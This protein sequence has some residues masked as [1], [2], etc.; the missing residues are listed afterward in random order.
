MTPAEFQ[1]A[2]IAIL[3]TSVGWQSKIADRLG[4]N[5]RAVRRWLV[6]GEIPDTIAAEMAA[7]MGMADATTFPRGE[8]LVGQDDAGRD[9]IYHMQAPR[10]IAR[11]IETDA[12][13]LPL[14]EDQP[15]DVISGGPY[16]IDGADDGDLVLCEIDW[17][18][19]PH[20]GEITQ[21]MEAAADMIEKIMDEDE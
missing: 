2:A 11:I 7:L 14:P 6:D 15:A 20:T 21:L 18:D 4:V 9:L 5:S 10:F 1:T 17:I 8:W 19:R 3:R 13:G 16:V 12:D